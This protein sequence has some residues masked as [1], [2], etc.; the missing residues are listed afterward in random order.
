MSKQEQEQER[1]AL[2]CIADVSS[3]I[4]SVIGDGDRS[5]SRI[6][7]GVIAVLSSAEQSGR[8][9]SYKIDHITISRQVEVAVTLHFG[10][11]K[12]MK[13]LFYGAYT[14]P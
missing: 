10:Q 5:R 13:M 14:K 3:Q 12:D 2:A 4:H 1:K 11:K 7:N 9:K 6:W 8:L